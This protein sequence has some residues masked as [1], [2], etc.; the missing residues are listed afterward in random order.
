[1]FYGRVLICWN[2]YRIY[3]LVEEKL[4]IF[5]KRMEIVESEFRYREKELEEVNY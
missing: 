4:D 1:M 3:R 2:F 5:I